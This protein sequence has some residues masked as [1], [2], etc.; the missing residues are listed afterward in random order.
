MIV[1]PSLSHLLEGQIFRK[2]RAMKIISCRLHLPRE[3]LPYL[4]SW[5]SLMTCIPCSNCSAVGF[6]PI[7]ANRPFMIFGGAVPCLV[8]LGRRFSFVFR[9]GDDVVP[10]ILLEIQAKRSRVSGAANKPRDGQVLCKLGGVAAQPI[11]RPA[12]DNLP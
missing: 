6:S 12:T 4:K 5:S 2:S 3:Y 8:V 7:L 1:E 11:G 9:E 10:F